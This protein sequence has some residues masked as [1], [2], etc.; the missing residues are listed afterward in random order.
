MNINSFHRFAIILLV[1]TLSS[2]SLMPKGG[3][4]KSLTFDQKRRFDQAY[5]EASKLKVLGDFTGSAKLFAD[6]LKI[7]PNNHAAMYQL[8]NLNMAVKSYHEAIYWSERSIEHNKT[9]NFWYYG[10]LAQAYSKVSDFKKSAETFKVMMSKDGDR[11]SNYIEAGNQYINAREFKLAISIFNSYQKKF[12]IDEESA[13]KKEG[14]Y[15]EMGKPKEAISAMEELVSAYPNELRYQ[16]LLAESY[17]RAQQF[18]D[19]IN[20]YQNILD[21]DDK[22]GF[23]H[24]GLADVYRRTNKPDESF[25][26]LSLAFDDPNV[27]SDLK[28]KV[29]GTYYPYIRTTEKMRIQAL[30]LGEKLIEVHPME[31]EAYVAYGDILY[32]ASQAPEARLNLLKATTIDASNMNVWRK[33]LSLDDEVGNFQHLFEDSKSVLELFPNHTFL[34]IVN[35]F[36]AYAIKDFKSA[37]KVAKDGLEISVVVKDQ[38]DLLSTLADASHELGD[39]EESDKAFEELLELDPENDGALNNYAYYLSLREVKLE[40]ALTMIKKALQ[41]RPDQI[42]YT[43]TYGWILYQMGL[44]E[45]ALPLLKEAYERMSDAAEVVEHYANVLIKT[46]KKTEGEKLLLE[47]EKIRTE[48]QMLKG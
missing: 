28:I 18:Q 21:Q 48:N 3:K 37:Q 35:S 14:M 42:T 23:A 32:A 7:D 2:C 10:Q 39:N 30:E 13:R 44:Y 43:D 33:I 17:V 34:Y 45:E 31:A 38:I 4:Q 27:S 19:A 41:I 12:G 24:F 8:A 1:I 5:F 46:G 47:A 11:K 15:Y 22:N 6:A 9:Y 26:H 16:G 29:M 36:A 20:T 40:K 25:N